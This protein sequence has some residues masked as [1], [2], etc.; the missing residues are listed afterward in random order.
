MKASLKPVV[1]GT[2]LVRNNLRIY[3]ILGVLITGLIA[4]VGPLGA[5]TIRQPE[6][7]RRN[8]EILGQG[9]SY[10]AVAEGYSAL[11]T[12]PAGIA[13]TEKPELTLP[14]TTIWAHSRPDLLLS[15]IGAFSGD[16]S[17]TTADGE[18]KSRQDLIIDTLREQFTTNGFGLGA[19]MGIGYVGNRIGIGLEAGFDS[20]LYG[21]TFPLG[22]EGE[23][24]S[25]F[26]LPVGYAHPFEIGPVSLAL[27]G[28]LRPTIRVSS[29]VDSDTAAD[30]ITTFTGVDTGETEA[31]DESDDSLFDTLSALNGWGVAFDTG[32]IARYRAVSL[33]IQAR[34]LLNTQMD[35]SNNSFQEI[36]DAA[37]QG[38]LPAKPD[39]S[40]DSSY[41]SDTYVIPTEVTFGAAWQPDLGD[42]SFIFDPEIHGQITDPFGLTDVDPDRPRSFWTRIHLGTEMTFL[43]FFDLRFGINQGYFTAGAGLDLSFLE[44][45]FAMYSEEYGRYPGDQQVG[46]AALEMAIRF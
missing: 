25:R 46:G 39:D 22:L 24:T 15:T 45:H 4:G 41:V 34:N 10:T 21:P 26:T 38:G 29:F 14:S 17:E 12:N 19:A 16:A 31:E 40:D 43:R 2:S 37:G 23:I 5:E 7:R 18:E 9:G 6:F 1:W 8:P 42:Y 20:Y 27:G 13:F 36:I 33:G 32:L 3:T 11:L 35:Y 30:L 28:T 44:I